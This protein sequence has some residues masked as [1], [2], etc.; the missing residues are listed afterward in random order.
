MLTQCCSNI[1]AFTVGIHWPGSLTKHSHMDR[2]GLGARVTP[3]LQ[4]SVMAP[5]SALHLQERCWYSEWIRTSRVQ[6]I[7]PL[8]NLKDGCFQDW[9]K[10]TGRFSYLCAD[11][12]SS[13]TAGW[14]PGLGAG[15]SS[16][17]HLT[18][19]EAGRKSQSS[20]LQS[21][22]SPSPNPAHAERGSAPVATGSLL[23]RQEERAAFWTPLISMRTETCPGATAAFLAA[24]LP[25]AALG[26]ACQICSSSTAA[27]HCTNGY[28][29]PQARLHP[30]IP[31]GV[32]GGQ[33]SEKWPQYLGL[34]AASQGW[35][36]QARVLCPSP[37]LSSG[38]TALPHAIRQVT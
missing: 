1:Q 27:A 20:M 38:G 11:P 29:L 30:W 33:W 32:T 8:P 13:P 24:G 28:N 22:C 9:R 37:P 31:A 23:S 26:D 2:P 6:C 4:C 3:Q 12:L 10:R 35:I 5:L 36:R 16:P 34:C 25:P 18:R 17:A 15:K 7:K 21:C 14:A 19:S